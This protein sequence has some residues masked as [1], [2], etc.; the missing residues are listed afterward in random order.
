AAFLRGEPT[1]S[2]DLVIAADVF[3][4]LGDLDK[5]FGETGRVIG[6]GGLFAFSVQTG[7]DQDWVVGKDLRYAHSQAYLRRLA[8]ETG[9]AVASIDDVSSRKDAGLDV[10]G[11]VCVLIKT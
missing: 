2:A 8:A 5:V 3:I 11:L 6:P 10:P 9:F 4:Y 1:E 7:V